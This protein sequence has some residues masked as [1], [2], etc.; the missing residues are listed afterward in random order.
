MSVSRTVATG[1]LLAA[2]A[3][4]S[5]AAQT[6]VHPS[7]AGEWTLDPAGTRTT[8]GPIVV[9]ASRPGDPAAPRIPEPAKTKDVRPIYPPHA[10]AA[11][12]TGIVVVQATVD[13]RGRVADL[14]V[15]RSI[16]AL[17][18]AAVEA[19]SQW[20]YTPAMLSGVAVPVV[21]TVTV[22]FNLGRGQSGGSS[23]RLLAAASSIGKGGPAASLAIKQDDNSLKITRES[24]AGS[25]TVT[26]RLDGKE[27]RNTLRGGG[28]MDGKYT[29]TSRWDEGRLVSRI[30]FRGPQGPSEA[31][32]IITVDKGRLVIQ[33]TRPVVHGAADPLVR[34][35][36]YLPKR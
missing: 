24:P 29:Y 20:E 14:E 10:I 3:G 27:S 8:G 12:I 25:E 35:H 32:E 4:P 33:T 1:L 19:V 30:S 7:F 34:T 16:P 5:A 18:H 13:A 15:V 31:A 11:S 21:L 28:A 26:Y 22:T 2:M 23:D 36:V 17:D 9:G 6:P